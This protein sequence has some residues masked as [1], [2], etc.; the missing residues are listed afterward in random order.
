MIQSTGEVQLPSDSFN[1]D[2]G[3]VTFLIISPVLFYVFTLNL[4][5]ILSVLVL[6]HCSERQLSKIMHVHILYTLSG[7]LPQG[8]YE[9]LSVLNTK[10]ILNKCCMYYFKPQ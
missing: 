7:C 1:Y 2:G 10:L 9:V 5:L 8:K 4:K 6:I 3:G